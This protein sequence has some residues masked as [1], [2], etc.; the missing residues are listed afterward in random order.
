MEIQNG[1]EHRLRANV[2][3]LPSDTTEVYSYLPVTG[4]STPEGH[5]TF[6][7]GEPRLRSVPAVF[8][9]KDI[10]NTNGPTAGWNSIEYFGLAL[11]TLT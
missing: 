4:S 2:T 6:C 1:L 11:V 7:G 9:S 10:A 5:H 3:A 8:L